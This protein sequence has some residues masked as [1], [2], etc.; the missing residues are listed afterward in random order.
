MP[1]A[2]HPA[3]HPTAPS[4][5]LRAVCRAACRAVCRAA[6]P[7]LLAVLSPAPSAGAGE[8]RLGARDLVSLGAAG[9]IAPGLVVPAPDPAL[10]TVDP[11]ATDP[12]LVQLRGLASLRRAADFGGVLYDNRDRGHSDLPARRFPRL[13]RLAW[14]PELAAAGLDYGLGG[15]VLVPAI[16]IGNSSTAIRDGPAPRSLP[17]LA[18]TSAEG[19]GRAFRAYA[20]NHLYVYP[21]HRDHDDAVDLFPAA[22]PYMAVSEGSSG[23]DQALLGA[24]LATVAAFPPETRAVLAREGLVAPALQMI[25]RRTLARVRGPGDY[26]TGVAHPSAVAAADLRPQAMVALAAAMRPDEVPGMV[27]LSV[28][29]EDFAPA[30]GLG[31]LS[32]RLF[33][34]P[35]AVARVF[36]D[37]VWEK[38]VTL[39]AAATRDP[40]GRPLAFR[41]ALLRGDPAR[42]RIEPLD[43]A[44]RRARITVAWHDAVP[45]PGGAAP[46]RTGLRADIGV[47]ADNGAWTGA[48]AILSVS[49]P[50]HEARRYAPGPDGAMRLAEVDYDAPGRGR[51]FDPVLHW[52]APWRDR[53]RP[54][55]DGMPEGIERR[56]SGGAAVP[57]PGV[58]L[59]VDRSRP[60]RP[61]LVPSNH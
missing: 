58:P 55:R 46:A 14:A 61:V 50:V 34:T 54:A 22:W 12:A 53:L 43:P 18:M 1:P 60:A 48:P 29:A 57:A 26:L 49:F 32:E 28:E 17:R 47:F 19:P 4:A 33:D 9:W 20:A 21:A 16:V 2:A 11:A 37:P 31:G 27:R 45:A 10:P 35:S 42:V 56:G 13:G 40:N 44:G 7:A 24:L 52:S 51:S 30:A 39:S 41:W 8:V 38:S 23:S 36:R 25:L 5:A 6:L 59:A 3:A 15:R